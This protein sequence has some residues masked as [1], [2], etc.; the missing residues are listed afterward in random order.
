MLNEAD[1]HPGLT[2]RLFAR[3]ARE[4]FLGFP[5]GAR[6]LKP[7]R[8]T[9]VEAFGN[10]IEPPPA[11]RPDRPAAR[12]A[13]G[14][15]ANGLVLLAVGGSQGAKA[16]NDTLAAWVRRGLPDG[17]HLLW[18]TGKNQYEPYAALDGA[19]GDRVR[20]RPYLSPIAEAYAAADL[21]LTRAGAMTIAELCAWGI[22]SVLVPL[23]TAA[24]DHQTHNARAMANAGAAAERA[25]ARAARRRGRR[26]A[27]GVG[28]PGP[29]RAG[30]GA[31][32]PR[33]RRAHRGSRARER[34]WR[35]HLTR[36]GLYCAAASYVSPVCSRSPS[37]PLRRRRR[38]RNE[39]PR[40]APRAARRHRHR[41]RRAP[42]ARG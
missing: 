32:P 9:R 29:R 30:R 38:R 41:V 23:P 21:A 20:V 1:S 8:R 2:T 19:S 14:F 22:P 4:V 34:R 33:R 13:W 10:P 12:A 18:A 25:H 17:V 40:R 42:V 7:G 15:P 6:L 27:F 11:V 3:W 31:R 39:R 35:S 26:A 24:A 36:A 28:A 5:E 37:G 16:I